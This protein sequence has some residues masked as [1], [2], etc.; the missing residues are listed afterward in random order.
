MQRLRAHPKLSGAVLLALC[1][2]ASC[3]AYGGIT[4]SLTGATAARSA[5]I[6]DLQPPS[7]LVTDG[8]SLY[9]VDEPLAR[10]VRGLVGTA[11]RRAELS[12]PVT[13]RDLAVRPLPP[14]PS[15]L[16]LVLSALA[17]LG[18]YQGSRSFRR[19]HL[20][21]APDWYHTGGPAQVGHVTPFDL[22]FG[23]LPLCV[24]D[25]PVARP[26]FAYRV[27]RE[28]ASRLHCQHFLS[29]ESPRGPP[30]TP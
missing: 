29:I 6:T 2:Y 26:A 22:E 16:S 1:A 27:P 11:Q 5:S 8:R 25:Q 7:P 13:P 28:R 12:L 17:T 21:S 9:D 20:S 4:S 3:A 10:S 15:S 30:L 24:F 18:A 23:T 14:A 19:L